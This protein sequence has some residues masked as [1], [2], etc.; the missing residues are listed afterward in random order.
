MA[1]FFSPPLSNLPELFPG[2]IRGN[3]NDDI[4]SG[5]NTVGRVYDS[6]KQT[7]RELKF[8]YFIAGFSLSRNL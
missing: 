6:G 5:W 7:D 2:A 8:L 3:Q 4:G 1:L